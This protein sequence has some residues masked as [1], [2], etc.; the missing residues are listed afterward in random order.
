MSDEKKFED[1]IHAQIEQKA[2]L[3]KKK[4]EVL[5]ME[6]KVRERRAENA[7]DKL[8]END[9]YEEIARTT[10]YGTLSEE[11][12]LSK[13]KENTEY[14]QAA[15]HK[16]RF[17]NKKFDDIVPFFRKNLI[18][19]GGKTGEGKS[20]TV[21]NIVY[22]TIELLNPITRKK[23]RVLVLTNEEK[24][25]DV[26]NR[27]TCLFKKWAYVNHDQ[28]TDE[29]VETFNKYISLLSRDGMVTVID[30]TYN[31]AFGTTTTLE[32][33][34]QIFDNLIKNNEV[35]D[36]VIL[37]Y[38]QN[39]KESRKNPM[40][41]EWEVQASLVRKL[42]QYKNVY[43][44]PI[45]ILA[46]VTPDSEGGGVPFKVRI[47]GRKSILNVATCALE[48]VADREKLCTEWIIHKS[49]FN[50]AVGQKISTGYDK[51][52]YVLYD[53]AFKDNVNKMKNT[54]DMRAFDKMV[55]MPDTKEK[56]EK[57]DEVPKKTSSD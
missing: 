18:L 24:S 16:M 5:E 47:E 57:N 8:E 23:R 7:I 11:E 34:C 14:M 12:I 41:N 4:N 15:R 49:R 39:I 21:A 17:V 26:Y 13:Q 40:M 2:L 33:I 52:R 22:S 42:D 31:G 55:K 9:K 37:D 48:M 54:R 50:Q 38:Y 36:V 30:D 25:E 19:V 27:V 35:Y 32:G 53:D 6:L 3:E 43:P 56:E 44:G 45:V 10:N 20:T 51:G 1:P 46:Q 28:F 29:Q